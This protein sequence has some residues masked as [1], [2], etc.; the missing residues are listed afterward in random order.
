MKI[1]GRNSVLETLK[2]DDITIMKLFLQN[3]LHGKEYNEAAELAKARHIKIQFCDKKIIENEL[4]DIKRANFFDRQSGKD[5]NNFGANQKSNNQELNHQG[6]LAIVTDYKYSSVDDI[7]NLAKS[8]NEDEFILILNEVT[9]VHNFGNI[10]R[11]AE[12][13]GVH[14][15]IISKD[16]NAQ[17]N[18][19]ALK[20]SSG[21]ANHIKIA[22]VGNLAQTIDDLKNKNIFIYGAEIG[23]D[24]VYKTNL[25]GKTAIVIGSEGE[26]I[27]QLI[28]KKCDAIVTIPQKGKVNSLNAGVAAGVVLFEALRQRN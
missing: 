3:G 22:R 27:K 7:L 17:V 2:N 21:A 28:K 10:I 11:T 18:E 24:N 19:T 5:K 12:C 26:G 25:K 14:G 4:T 6:M 1:Y 16:R 13:V 23:G 8:K 9:D 15:I 20:I